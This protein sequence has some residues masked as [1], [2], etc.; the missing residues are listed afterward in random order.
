MQVGLQAHLEDHVGDG[1]RRV[2]T[3]SLV[4]KVTQRE[5]QAE[6]AAPEA[7]L[8]GVWSYYLHDSSNG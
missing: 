5:A 7:F 1:A 6:A 8:P 3:V 4:E 2:H